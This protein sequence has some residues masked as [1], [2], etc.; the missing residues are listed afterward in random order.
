MN[1]PQVYM[2]FLQKKLWRCQLL[3]KGL[4]LLLRKSMNREK[5]KFRQS[6]KYHCKLKKKKCFY[7][8]PRTSVNV[9]SVYIHAI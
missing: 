2:C 9:F 5:V 7:R 6:K 1:P 8:C 4:F 3:I